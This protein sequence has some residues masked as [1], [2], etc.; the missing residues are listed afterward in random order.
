MKVIAY[1]L[2]GKLCIFTPSEGARLA[3]DVTLADGQVVSNR[4]EVK[5]AI[6]E[7]IPAGDVLGEDGQPLV[8]ASRRVEPAVY[9][10]RA[11]P[12]D[13][14]M[15]GWPVDGATAR[16]AETEDEFLARVQERAVPPGA[17]DVTVLDQ[18]QIPKDRASRATWR[19]TP[20]GIEVK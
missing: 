3:F 17:Q 7:E 8:P 10:D 11:L 18:C 9:E 16:W 19:L 20:T 13:R 1:M 5:A 2:E 12:V 4:V 15:R 14:F 6:D